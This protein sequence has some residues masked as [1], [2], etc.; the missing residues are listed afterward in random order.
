MPTKPNL[1]LYLGVTAAVKL[2][3]MKVK[4]CDYVQALYHLDTAISK[5]TTFKH[6][7][8]WWF[9]IKLTI[10]LKITGE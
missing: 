6:I 4:S 10:K 9:E 7:N 3:D 8:K 5:S 2:Q 1:R